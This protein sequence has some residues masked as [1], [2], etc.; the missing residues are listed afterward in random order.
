MTF[1]IQKYHWYCILNANYYD[2][3]NI[4]VDK[5][6]RIDKFGPIK[7]SLNLFKSVKNINYRSDLL[8]Q[9]KFFST[10]SSAMVR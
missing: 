10:V 4:W 2:E 5:L 3:K 9:I 7:K 8:Q 1:T 6:S